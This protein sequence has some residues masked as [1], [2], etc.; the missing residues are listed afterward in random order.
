[1]S[2]GLLY[3]GGTIKNQLAKFKIN[4]EITMIG[5]LSKCTVKFEQNGI[6]IGVIKC[7]KMKNIKKQLVPYV[8]LD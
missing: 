3:E 5:N 4:D 6:K 8:Y 2:N 7:Y 1:M